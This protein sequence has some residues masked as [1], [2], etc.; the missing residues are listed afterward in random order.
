L[1]PQYTG[2]LTTLCKCSAVTAV[3]AVSPIE[4]PKAMIRAGAAAL[5]PSAPLVR[6]PPMLVPHEGI[7]GLGIWRLSR[8]L[9]EMGKVW[10]SHNG[11]G[12][13]YRTLLYTAHGL[14][15]SFVFDITNS[16]SI[17]TPNRVR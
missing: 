4:L 15:I 1:D 10:P 11:W 12:T 14:Y 5:K 9:G 2:L 6:I 17:A 8:D 16:H 3:V 7:W 13:T